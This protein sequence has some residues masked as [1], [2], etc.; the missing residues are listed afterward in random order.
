MPHLSD[1]DL[2]E[3]TRNASRFF[4]E[5]RQIAW[6]A[7]V[8]SVAWGTYGYFSMPQR[9]DP[10]I[11]VRVGVALCRWPGATAQEVEQL[12]TRPIEQAIAENKH[13]HPAAP[14]EYG[15]RSISLPGTSIVYVQLAENVTNTR[16]QFSD[17]NLKL[18]SLTPKLPAGATGIQFQSDFGDTAALMMTVADPLEDDVE[19]R[20]RALSVEAA[21]R[22]ARAGTG[23]SGSPRVSIVFTFPQSLSNTAVE[24]AA[25]ALRLGAER[26]GV[27]RRSRLIAG[28][29][30]MDIEGESDLNDECILQFI[31]SFAAA[32]LQESEFDP[33]ISAPVIIRDARETRRK[34]AAVAIPKYTYAELDDFTDLIGRTLLGAPQTSKVE[35]KGILPRA[36]Y[37]DYSQ[38]RLASYGLQPADLAR[39]LNARNITV[40][41]GDIEA[42]RRR[43]PI[44]VSGKFEA[45]RA[46]GDV[47]ITPPKGALPLYLRDLVHIGQGYQSPPEYLNYYTGAARDGK[48]RRY[49]AITLAVY[50][51]S[52][53]QIRQFGAS[54]DEKWKQVRAVL[55]ADLIV[56]RTSDQPLQV[57]ENIGL[58]MEALYEAIVL[59]VLIALIGF[60]EWRSALLMALSMP[61]TLAITFGMAHMARVE[62]QQVSIATLIIALGLLVDNPVVANDAIKRHLADGHPR[63]VAAWLGPTKLSR[64]ILYATLTNII[65]YL[66]FLML[67]GS[68]GDFLR[69]LPIVMAAA[70]ISSLMVSKTFTPLL[71]YYLLRA[72]RRPEPSIEERRARGFYGAYYRLAG[73]AIR[74]RW[75]VIGIS[76]LFLGLG[77]AVGSKMKSQF[78][79]D[80][81]Q[82]WSYVDI[83]LPNDA[84]LYA[85]DAAASR[86]ESIVRRV[87][88]EY[89]RAHPSKHP[90]ELLESLTTFV[91]GGGPRFWYS[92]APELPQRN[93]SLILIR[94]RDKE[95]TPRL[96]GPL[97]SAV[98]RE[99]PGA[100]VTLHQLQTNPVEFP[101]EVRIAGTSD[102]DVKDEPADIE[103]L[104]RLAAAVEN[105]FRTIPGVHV[106][107]ND[108]FAESPEVKLQVDPD[109]A[110][111][112]GV[113][114]ID[115]AASAAT[116]TEGTAVTT[117][118][119]GN[120]Q[121]PVIAR[122]RALE[123]GQLSDV[124]NLYV[125]SSSPASQKVPLRSVSSIVNRMVTGRIRRQEHF[126]TI[127]VH[128]FPQA[129]VLASEILQKAGPELAKF[130]KHLPPGYRMQVGGEKAKQQSGFGELTSVL[131][132]SIL[133]IYAALLVQFGNAVKPLLV[134]AAA[135]YGITGALL[136]LALMGVPFGFMAF[137]GI[138]SLIGVIVSHV[139]VLFDFIE[140]MHEKG[141]PFEQAVRDAGIQRLRPVMITV[142]ATVLALFPLATHGGP[143]WQPLCY[144]QIGGLAVATFIT[145]L[146][147]PVFYS[148]AVLDLK[149]V[150]WT[151]PG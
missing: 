140:E 128:A 9:K 119:Q 68:T 108:W 130:Q 81:V 133:G 92:A 93:Y 78:F 79:P 132:I 28:R 109:R 31:T 98:S 103:T 52:G 129:G 30:F 95:A 127:G 71:G 89:A 58:F 61:I 25:G 118:R 76:L 14:D 39:I 85:T 12:V 136:C 32:R 121:I 59:V 29:G 110:N 106:V 41:G 34:L 44:D 47:L 73:R 147:V 116:A 45:A 60:W 72:P 16:E 87:A 125:Y 6:A 20:M 13:I 46:I 49:R 83:W 102:V 150:K 107:Q 22:S 113:S 123:R 84:A 24:E 56:V 50:M 149:I 64:A 96:I 115:V 23:P 40:P 146:L 57:K 144:A 74:W 4:V 137:L 11:P 3:R 51:R 97:Q 91:G 54:I 77:L 36:V 143:L 18:H 55:P 120:L 131:M 124:Q 33:D 86:V 48:P 126:R 53:E 7:L 94:L 38:E 112:A 104:R 90:G 67:T 111:L 151:A 99:V 117:L 1:R 43:I 100:Y 42:D 2:M 21:L 145:L 10:E 27:L 105:I 101:V 26:A 5:H 88:G 66:P 82:Y 70:L 62:L 138:I 63:S 19:T 141:E 69:S 37:L 142:A 35:R 75:A 8:F 139:I 17:I 65:A 122:L 135:P 114:N 15:I 80:D 148:V 134:L